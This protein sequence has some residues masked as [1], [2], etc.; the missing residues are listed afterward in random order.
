[1]ANALKLTK[2][3]VDRIPFTSSG[4]AYY[5][6]AE[7]TGFGL[8]VGMASKAYFA[9]WRVGGRA[10]RTVRKNIGKHGAFTPDGAR[11]RAMLLL[12]RMQLGEDPFV[13]ERSQRV[14]RMS[15]VEANKA[16][17]T[18]RKGLKP[19]TLRDYGY[20]F[21]RYFGDWHDKPLTSISRE[22][23]ARR[24]AL[25]GQ[26]GFPTRRKLERAPLPSPAKANLAMRYLRALFNFAINRYE[27]H[28][29]DNPVKHLSMTR[30]WYPV[31]RRQTYIKEHE[32]KPWFRAV[33]ALENDA[34]TQTRETARDYMLLLLFTGLR[35]DE[36][37]RL[38]W[39]NVDLKAR[40]LCIP[41]TKNREPHILPLPDFLLEMLKRRKQAAN[42]DEEQ[43][44]VFPGE[45]R[46]GHLIE[47]RK[48][49]LRACRESGV[50]FRLHDL[51]RSFATYAE[52]L[53]I[54]AYALKRL[55]NHKIRN[56]VTAGYII[57]DVERLRTPMQKVADF[58]LK[59]AGVKKTAEVKPMPRLDRP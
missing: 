38:N 40:T 58:I 24:H 1:M 42:D 3:A 21:E 23:V 59:A 7:L 11:K 10:G 56:D 35:R 51:R 16:F 31:E 22:M 44:Y 48:Q 52:R 50:D 32:L 54:P 12:G 41:D 34:Q 47:P 29:T 6:D 20:C 8:R 9:E 27:P 18:A 13:A 28:I 39:V 45:G 55:L 57:A 53:D 4:Q 2:S 19:N 30:G 15:L 36:G 17:L 5:Y 25:I 49:V 14:Q 26:T 46:R 33:M 43:Q 37:A